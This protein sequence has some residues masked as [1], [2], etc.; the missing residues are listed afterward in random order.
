MTLMDLVFQAGGLKESANTLDAEIARVDSTTI[1]TVQAAR[2][3][4]EPISADY[5]IHSQDSSFVLQQWDQVSV[6]EIPDWQLQRNVTLTGEVQY[7]GTYALQ[8]KDERLSSLIARAGGLKAT[9]YPRAATFTRKK[10][11]VGRLAVNVEAVTVHGNRR[12]DLVLED[13]DAIDIPREP[14]SVKVVGEVGFPASVLYERGRSLGY[15]IEQAGGYT[16]RSDKRRVR[17]VQPNGRVKAVS[18]FSPDTRP[19]PGALV[20]V[21]PKSIREKSETLKDVATIVGILS[22]AATTI[23]LVRQATK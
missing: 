14:K 13:G 7:P 8:A 9:A 6:R 23:F 4:R 17:V 1:A 18:R 20:L 12:Q 15:Y 16:E 21:P 2:I 19:D 10:D 3:F 11:D 5:G 22:G